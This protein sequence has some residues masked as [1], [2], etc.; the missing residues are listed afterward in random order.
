MM[1]FNNPPSRLFPARNTD[2]PHLSTP[3]QVMIDRFVENLCARKPVL[4]QP[5][6]ADHEL[7]ASNESALQAREALVKW[8]ILSRNKDGNLCATNYWSCDIAGTLDGCILANDQP[9][10]WIYKSISNTLVLRPE[11][12]ILD[13]LEL[14]SGTPVYLLKRLRW[15]EDGPSAYDLIFIPPVRFPASTDLQYSLRG[16]TDLLLQNCQIIAK[17]VE[18]TN[19]ALAPEDIADFL[20]IPADSEVLHIM[21]TLYNH[22]GL[23]IEFRNTHLHTRNTR[24]QTP[25]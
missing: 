17:A 25:F 7:L 9:P 16:A 11:K 3:A 4:P 24:Y 6:A 22:Q 20:D 15:V 12:E 1:Q 19:P 14:K 8:G 2:R 13:R 23:P 21:R 10:D 18:Q 5:L